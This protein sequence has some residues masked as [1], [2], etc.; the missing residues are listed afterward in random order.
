MHPAQ[1]CYGVTTKMEQ[2]LGNLEEGKQNK[3]HAH[4]ETIVIIAALAVKMINR[5]LDGSEDQY[6]KRSSRRKPAYSRSR[7]PL[8]SEMLGRLRG[9]VLANG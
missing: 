5:G 8:I 3:V 4:E 1:D 9:D 6:G 7:S 2:A